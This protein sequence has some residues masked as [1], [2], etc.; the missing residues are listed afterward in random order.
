LSDPF[1]IGPSRKSRFRAR[2]PGEERPPAPVPAPPEAEAQPETYQPDEF[3]AKA[4]EDAAPVVAVED[5]PATAA[6][7]RQ[8]SLPVNFY[9]PGLQVPWLRVILGVCLFAVGGALGYFI[10]GAVKSAAAERRAAGIAKSFR[11]VDKPPAL[12]EAERAQLD[13]A[14]SAGREGRYADSERMFSTLSQKHPDWA[15]LPLEIARMNIYQGDNI[16]AQLV[17]GRLMQQDSDAR[18]DAFFLAGVLNLKAASYADAEASF[19]AATDAD[20]TRSEY[21]Y[22]WGDCLRQEG[23]PREA[24]MRFRS[25]LARNQYETA[26]DLLQLKVWLCDITMDQEKKDGADTAINAG[27]AAPFPRAAALLAAAARALKA[28]NVSVASSFLAR[29]RASMDQTVFQ[30]VMHDPTF[31]QESWRPELAQFYMA[32]SAGPP[33]PAAK[34]GTPPP[35]PQ[36][37]KP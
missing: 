37:K 28:D 19:A 25:A 14:Y 36:A 1:Y 9:D 2:R 30:V 35:P 12:T 29:G 26:E 18:P 20:P 32:P 15:K 8:T 24:E 11:S 3:T 13:A 23:K 6:R 16:G 4:A 31:V 10:G 7:P 5:R 27:L 33:P 17:L 21:F 34:P 22:F